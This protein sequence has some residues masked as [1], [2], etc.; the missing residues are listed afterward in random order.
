[1]VGIFINPSTPQKGGSIPEGAGGFV[2]VIFLGLVYGHL[3]LKGSNLIS[4]GSELLLLIPSAAGIV[5]SVVLPVLGAVPDGAIVLF[6]GL[7]PGTA[8]EVQRQLTVGVGALAGSTVM[9]LTVPWFLSVLGGKVPIG[10][11]GPC[12][13]RQQRDALLN[14]RNDPRQ[15]SR[16]P[17]CCVSDGVAPDHK[18]RISAA[19][20]LATCISGY[21]I[22][23]VPALLFINETTKIESENLA[24]FAWGGAILCTTMFIGYL[25][26]QF[27]LAKEEE[28]LANVAAEEK[29]IMLAQKLISERQMSL[30][31]VLSFCSRGDAGE[32]NSAQPL[33]EQDRMTAMK[34]RLKRLIRPLFD[35]YDANGDGSLCR[36]ELAQMVGDL[37]ERV[38]GE[39]ETLFTEIDQDGS[40]SID[41]DE[42]CDWFA[43][44]VNQS[45]HASHSPRHTRRSFDAAVRPLE[46]SSAV[47][48][49]SIGAMVATRG[50]EAAGPSATTAA[51]AEGGE[52]EDDDDD[53]EQEWP[54]D[55]RDLPADEQRRIVLRRSFW[56]MALGTLI[57]L[58][59]S[60]PMV[61][62]FDTLG[63]R[64]GVPP[65]YVAFL[66][67]PIASNAS[68]MIA[69]YKYATKKTQKTISIAFAQLLGAACMNNTFCLGIFYF[70]VASRGLSWTYH[71][72]VMGIIVAELAVAGMACLRVHK[73]WHGALVLS[74][75]PLCLVVVWVL[76]VT[77]FEG[78]EA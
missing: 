10:D 42:C 13:T 50:T 2:Q 14:L 31:G 52:E 29:A 77:A 26:L 75:L 3:L 54:E 55:V 5:G 27:R 64:I 8:E 53:E 59:F 67:G 9:L 12:Y 61:D 68:E 66:L 32:G 37:G 6:S 69:S 19:V 15:V 56:Q 24:P 47:P 44:L 60:D 25:V 71:A 65:F 16:E 38:G 4:D 7:G 36:D 73:V 78:H 51:G 33:A 40:G 20:M 41:Y 1:M 76:K 70:L 30:G 62:V 48:A 28:D 43:K 23:E 35:K 39:L 57:V 72:E 18:I 63:D 46:T 21:L 17:N 11:S 34:S 22:V 45:A 74:F 58:L 49:L